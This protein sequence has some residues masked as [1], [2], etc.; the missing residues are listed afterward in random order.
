MWCT[1]WFCSNKY[2]TQD[3]IDIKC[4]DNHTLVLTSNGDVLT[5]K[6]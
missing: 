6:K 5:W 1:F 2:G 4:G 3:V